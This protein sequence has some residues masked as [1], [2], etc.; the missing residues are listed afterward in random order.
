MWI[1]LEKFAIFEGTEKCNETSN[2][3]NDKQKPG[4]R[5]LVEEKSNGNQIAESVFYTRFVFFSVSTFY[6]IILSWYQCSK[7]L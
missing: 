4:A 7:V 2:P 1:L 3:A 5:Q 6:L